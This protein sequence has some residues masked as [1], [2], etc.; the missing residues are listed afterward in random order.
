M[1]VHKKK[2]IFILHY[3]LIKMTG[4]FYRVMFNLFRF[5]HYK[6]IAIQFQELFNCHPIYRSLAIFSILAMVSPAG[7]LSIFR[8]Y[9]FRRSLSPVLTSINQYK[10]RSIIR[11]L[12]RPPYSY[13]IFN[14]EPW[15][16]LCFSCTKITHERNDHLNFQ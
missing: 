14:L 6:I 3:M 11:D 16:E 5:V 13:R 1:Q 8:T 9:L 4:F 12:R 2:C 7:W 10:Q 15:P